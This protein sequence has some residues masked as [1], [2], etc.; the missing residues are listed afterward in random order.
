MLTA[1]SSKLTASLNFRR[2]F[3]S[4]GAEDPS[5]FSLL[6]SSL[7]DSLVGRGRLGGLHDGVNLVCYER[8]SQIICIFGF[9]NSPVG[10]PYP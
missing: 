4:G 10:S 9:E 8:I 6:D 5:R 2:R 3:V 7:T 1:S